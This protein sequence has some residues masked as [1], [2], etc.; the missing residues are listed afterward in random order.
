MAQLLTCITQTSYDHRRTD[1]FEVSVS[2]FPTPMDPTPG[3]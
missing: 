3:L 1:H 2:D